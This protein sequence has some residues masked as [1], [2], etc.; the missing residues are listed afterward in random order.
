MINTKNKF[1]RPTNLLLTPLDDTLLRN[2]KKNQLTSW[3]I[4]IICKH[5]KAYIILNI[6]FIYLFKGNEHL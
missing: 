6:C 1:I 4:F 3:L 2:T 5:E